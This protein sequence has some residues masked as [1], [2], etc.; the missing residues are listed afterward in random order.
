MPKRANSIEAFLLLS[1]WL[2]N[3]TPLYLNVL[4]QGDVPEQFTGTLHSVD[5]PENQ[6]GFAVARTHELLDIDLTAALFVVGS[7]SLVAERFKDRIV[8]REFVH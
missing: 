2:R 5:I 7:D 6:I 1:K 3:M 4:K 8:L